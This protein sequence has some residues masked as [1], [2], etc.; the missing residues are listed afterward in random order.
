[1]DMA[2]PF[3]AQ[4]V[5]LILSNPALGIEAMRF[6]ATAT[7]AEIWQV[8]DLLIPIAGDWTVQ[9]EARVSDFDLRQWAGQIVLP[10]GSAN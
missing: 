3:A 2:A 1:M 8:Q 9:L 6:S 4:T 7:S 5:T 10:A